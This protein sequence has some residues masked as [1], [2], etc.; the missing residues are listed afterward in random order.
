[1]KIIKVE[2]TR[3]QNSN[4][5]PYRLT[6]LTN[7]RFI[8]TGW[9]DYLPGDLVTAGDVDELNSREGVE[10]SIV[11]GV[12]AETVEKP[13]ANHVSEEAKQCLADLTKA[14]SDFG[15]LPPPKKGSNHPRDSRGR[16]LP[17]VTLA[18]FDYWK[19]G[20]GTKTR[21]VVV[22]EVN[23]D[24]EYLRGTDLDKCD[25]RCFRRSSIVGALVK[26]ESYFDAENCCV[27]GRFPYCKS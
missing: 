27:I 9:V 5:A 6:R 17:K 1:M 24:E 20:D 23:S 18:E 22:D 7:A 16:F 25:Y 13:D 3:E 14:L 15:V 26:T 19:A 10:V 21:R 4:A 12:A 8:S 11:K 2:L